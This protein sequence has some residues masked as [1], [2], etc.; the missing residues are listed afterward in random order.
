MKNIR[1]FVLIG[2]FLIP[3]FGMTQNNR[4]RQASCAGGKAS[5]FYITPYIGLGGASYS[6]ELNSTVMDADSNIYDLEEGRMLTPIAGINFMYSL[7]RSNL[8]GGAEWQSFIGETDN[9]F[10]QTSRTIYLPKFFG[11]YEFAFY[12][13]SFSD[14]GAYL[15]GGLVFPKNTQGESVDMGSFFKIGL[16]YNLIINHT[17]SLFVGLD[18]Q[19]SSFTS[20]IGN[21]ISNH[22]TRDIKISIGYRFWF[23][24]Y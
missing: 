21:E 5:K 8:G 20:V 24:Q 23:D 6:F 3:L 4:T 12:S 18:Y 2:L 22:Y 10:T 9:G 1:T 19:Y 17:S 13:D 7:G 15:E 11:R 14:F 16:F